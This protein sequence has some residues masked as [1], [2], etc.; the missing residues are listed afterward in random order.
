MAEGWG[1]GGLDARRSEQ[2]GEKIEVLEK[3]WGRFLRSSSLLLMWL[4]VSREKE[5]N[6]LCP[7]PHREGQD[8]RPGRIALM[9]PAGL[10]GVRVAP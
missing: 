8:Q 1:T 5:G 7:L 4:V 6:P 2:Y 3:H 10:L 9:L